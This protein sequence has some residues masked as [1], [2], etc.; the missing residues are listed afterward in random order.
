M[1]WTGCIQ[2]ADCADQIAAKLPR[3]IKRQI[4][5]PNLNQN[6]QRICSRKPGSRYDSTAGK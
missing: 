4:G 6:R 1:S 3:Q 5:F 2:S